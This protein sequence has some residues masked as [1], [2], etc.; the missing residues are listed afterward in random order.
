MK[1]TLFLIAF[2]IVCFLGFAQSNIR[3]NNYWENTNYINPGSIDEKYFIELSTAA[4]KQWL[5]L[6]GSPATF[7]ALGTAYIEKM[8]TQLGLKVTQDKIGY[9]AASDIDL[10]YA[11][12]LKINSEWK[13][14]LGVAACYQMLSYD[15]S[16]MNLQNSSDPAASAGLLKENNFNANIGAELIRDSWKFGVASQNLFSL[17]SD[18]N[19]QYTNTNFLYGIYNQH[20]DQLV[21]LGLGVCGIKYGNL[22]QME[23][24]ATSYF[25]ITD[26]RFNRLKESEMFHVGLFYR[27]KNEMGVIFGIDMS[28]LLS[29]SYSY[30]FNLSGI[31]RSSIGTNE[32][33]LS[34]KMYKPVKCRNCNY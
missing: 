23:F 20:T 30:D 22:Y 9:T 25:D 27:T 28:N 26:R 16:Q 14:H 18:I 29:L 24:N 34:Y 5:N 1:R 17:F 10:S 13:L 19:K 3:L 33:I 32:L 2:N 21:N 6:P 12:A 8:H 15:L 4:R 31:S 7:F 11:Y